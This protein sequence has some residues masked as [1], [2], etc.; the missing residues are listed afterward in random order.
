[1]IEL[2]EPLSSSIAF[3]KGFA[4]EHVVQMVDKYKLEL[5]VDRGIPNFCP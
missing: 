1:M 3:P 4:R 5:T 2:D